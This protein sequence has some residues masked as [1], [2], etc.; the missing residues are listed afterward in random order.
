MHA[1]RAV[2]YS[3]LAHIRN[4]GT[5]IKGPLDVFT[6][7]IKRVLSKMNNEG[8]HAGES[9]LEIKK[10]AFDLYNIDFPIPVLKLILR[11]ICSEVNTNEDTRIQIYGDGSFSIKQYTFKEFDEVV[12]QQKEDVKEL[13][14]FFKE[15]C[16]S[17]ELKVTDT[18]SIF[19]FIE[20]NKF[21]LSK[22][23]VGNRKPNGEDFTAEA[24]FVD[25]FKR[26]PPIYERI[27]NIYLGSI[28]SSYIEY[29]PEKENRDLELL[30]DTNFI[31]GLID[32]NTQESTHT[33]RTLIDIARLNKFKLT[34]LIDTIEETKNLLNTK[35]SYFDKS[36]LQKKVNPE[37]VFNA[38]DRRALSKVDLEKISDNL[39][40]SI[41]NLGINVVYQTDKLKNVS[42]FTDEYKIFEELRT[43]KK[44]ALHDAMAIH[45]VKQKRKNIGIKEFERVNCWFVNNSTSIMSES[46]FSIN[47]YQPETIKVDDLL[48]ILWLSNPQIQSTVNG[49][50][51]AEIGLTSLISF[52]LNKNLPKAQIIKELDDNI[53]KYSSEGISD[54]DIVRVATR[55]TNKQLK[56]IEEL[57]SL[58]ES[59]KD[60]F[61]KRL[62]QEAE[63]QKRVEEK[64][65]E[66]LEELFVEI[67]KKADLF[68]QERKLLEQKND[69]IDEII[70]EKENSAHKNILLQKELIKER[71]N[72]RKIQR[73]GFIKT[74]V[75]KWRRASWINLTISIVLFLIAFLYLL[76]S[77]DWELEKTISNIENLNKN[78][79]I[80]GI[81]SLV[82]L[83]FNLFIINNL[84]G[85]YCNHSNIQSFKNSI[86]IPQDLQEIKD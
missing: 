22:Y 66:K 71:N 2:T 80:S 86:E 44:S 3:L 40:D 31:V 28:I 50:D 6:P 68:D 27:K 84:Y 29:K 55:I 52:T 24:Q 20:K 14:R 85:K 45:Y 19:K 1:Q 41:T 79:I 37:D 74:K 21:T 17:S 38:C 8:I 26:I 33:C 34:V 10:T 49:D 32:L 15:F 72:V 78:L 58:A 11:A 5:L 53:H 61:V 23:L 59:D 67:S 43:S 56:N 46:I 83:F 35:A 65:I 77:S 4:N 69:K 12:E 18:E 76:N 51:L 30:L 7:L 39:E 82:T 36:F 64:R 13:E 62:E 48:N 70:I 25:F 75:E 73:E 47:G 16:E 54:K 9:I 57:N 42:K 63:N 81:F 60:E